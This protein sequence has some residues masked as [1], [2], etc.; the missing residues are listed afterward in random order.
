MYLGL[1]SGKYILRLSFVKL[2]I[3]KSNLIISQIFNI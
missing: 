3:S 2:I 1:D